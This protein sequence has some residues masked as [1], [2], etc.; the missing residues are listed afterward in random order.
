MQNLYTHR[1]S[2]IRKT[3][4]LM[5][6]FFILIIGVGYALSYQFGDVNILYIA[7]AISIFMNFAAYWW[8][9]S[10]ALAMSG[11]Q[12]VPREQAPQLYRMVENLCITAGLPMPKI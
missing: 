1:A 2:N 5:A 8:S 9:A 12:A 7:I 10:I 4:L 11:A 3:F 6:V